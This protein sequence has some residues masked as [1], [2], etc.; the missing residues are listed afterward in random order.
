MFHP[1]S[2]CPSA[3]QPQQLPRPARSHTTALLILMPAMP[4]R[5]KND[6]ESVRWPLQLSFDI[7][8]LLST[9]GNPDSYHRKMSKCSLQGTPTTIAMR[10]NEVGT[11]E[12]TQLRLHLHDL[13]TLQ[14]ASSFACIAQFI[15]AT[16]CNVAHSP[17][18]SCSPGG[19][20]SFFS[21]CCRRT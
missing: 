13:G 21:R 12:D 1:A 10:L 4:P 19:W 16:F 15:S 20:P 18:M 3:T 7:K 8:L 5:T 11:F 2:N 14:Q 17:T 6:S 9:H